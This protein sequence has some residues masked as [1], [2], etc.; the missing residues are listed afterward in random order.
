VAWASHELP[1]R[2]GIQFSDALA[3]QVI[4]FMRKLLG[5]VPVVTGE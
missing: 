5:P 3:E 2:V 1:C 4:P